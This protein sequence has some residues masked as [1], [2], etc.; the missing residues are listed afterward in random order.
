M[1]VFKPK[2]LVNLS[3]LV[4]VPVLISGCVIG[5]PGSYAWHGSAS[6]KEKVTYFRNICLEYGHLR[7]TEELKKCTAEEMRLSKKMA[8][9]RVNSRTYP[10]PWEKTQVRCTSREIGYSVVTECE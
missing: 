7:N 3:V 1:G 5:D 10:A 4:L 9:D 6:T 2:S 8:D